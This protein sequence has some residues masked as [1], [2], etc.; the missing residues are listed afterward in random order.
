MLVLR[1][2]SNEVCISVEAR[3]V[4]VVVDGYS[5]QSAFLRFL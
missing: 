1:N 3:D 2:R 4:G 5:I